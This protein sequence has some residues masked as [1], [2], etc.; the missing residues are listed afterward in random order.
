MK[1]C[2]EKQNSV[3]RWRD[4]SKIQDRWRPPYLQI[5]KSPY[6]NEKLSD[7][8]EIWYTTAHL[9]LDDS[10]HQL[11]LNF[12]MA[13]VHRFK[14]FWPNSAADCPISVKFCV[15]KQ[16]CT[17]FRQWDRYPRS[18]ECIFPWFCA[19]NFSQFCRA[20]LCIGASYAVMRCL[21]V[22]LLSVTFV[23][24][25]NELTYHQFFFTIA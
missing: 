16:F 24:C 8:Y 22:C 21:S 4:I 13:D 11:L 2:T 9:E 14:V 19:Q 20:M 6:L 1:F 15:G 3:A 12:K 10:Q 23:S 25:Q 17:E 7:F 18:I 5:V